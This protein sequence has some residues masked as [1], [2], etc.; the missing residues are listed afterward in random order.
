MNRGNELSTSDR[1]S[2]GDETSTRANPSVTLSLPPV[3]GTNSRSTSVAYAASS[4]ASLNLFGPVL[5]FSILG[6]ARCAV[7]Q[8]DHHHPDRLDHHHRPQSVSTR[9]L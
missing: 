6:D 5:L 7:G 4:H 8:S 2:P 9:V 3:A 1:F